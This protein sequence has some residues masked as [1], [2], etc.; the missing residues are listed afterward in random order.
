MARRWQQP[1][2]VGPG[3]GCRAGTPG[4]GHSRGSGPFPGSTGGSGRGAG[5]RGLAAGARCG[6]RGGGHGGSLSGHS[7]AVVS[8]SPPGP[9]RR[10]GLRQQHVE[11]GKNKLFG[12]QPLQ[13]LLS[14]LS[15][16]PNKQGKRWLSR[17]W[18]AQPGRHSPSCPRSRSQARRPGSS[19]AAALR[20]VGKGL[21][22]PA[23]HRGCAPPSG[24][25]AMP[26]GTGQ[27]P[28][29]PSPAVAGGHLSLPMDTSAAWEGFPCALLRPAWP[30]ANGRGLLCRWRR[31]GCQGRVE[32]LAQSCCGQP[33][34]RG[35]A[36]THHHLWVLQ[37]NPRPRRW[38]Q[39]AGAR[40]RGRTHVVQPCVGTGT[41]LRV[42]RQAVGPRSCQL[43]GCRR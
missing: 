1:L 35:R 42:A 27:L 13:P 6:A 22:S 29:R 5:L 23:P 21:R 9:A 39:A 11:V 31:S 38:A 43:E 25:A 40:S 4:R 33:A 17:S 19:P 15:G 32:G 26:P 24:T 37:R 20:G 7:W 2:T 34:R 12:S 18:P 28:G 3:P 36:L 8:A 14:K 30:P 41:S 16:S 10:C